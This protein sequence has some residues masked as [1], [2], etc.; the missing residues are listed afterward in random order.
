MRKFKL[1]N[2]DRLPQPVDNDHK[3]FAIVLEDIQP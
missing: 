3:I 1:F 2:A